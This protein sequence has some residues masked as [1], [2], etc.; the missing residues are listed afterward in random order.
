MIIDIRNLML[1]FYRI[2]YIH[3]VNNIEY[4]INEIILNEIQ[5]KWLQ[6]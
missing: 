3:F 6:D 1:H 2:N 5:N 4:L